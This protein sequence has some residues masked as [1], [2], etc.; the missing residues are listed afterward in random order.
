MRDDPKNPLHRLDA[1]KRAALPG[2]DDPYE[3][4]GSADPHETPLLVVIMG[5]EHFQPGRK[6]YYAFEYAHIGNLEFEITH[7]GNAFHFVYSGFQPKLILVYGDDVLRIWHQIGTRQIPWIREADRDFRPAGARSDKP[8]IT[9]VEVFDWARPKPQAEELAKA[10][11]AYE[12][13]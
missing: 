9:K 6:P 1:A 5:K 11:E 10:R 7:V 4:A 13:A 2:P 8:I 12:E 3:A